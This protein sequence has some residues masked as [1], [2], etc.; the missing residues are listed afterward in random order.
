VG[1]TLEQICQRHATELFGEWLPKNGAFPLLVKLLDCR[2]LLS[3]QVHPNDELARHLTSEVFGKT[4]AW[5]I[6][7]AEPDA[8]IYA[9]FQSGVGRD[10]VE[11][12][13]SAG[14][15]EEVLHT[16]TPRRGD[17]VFLPAGTVHA[18][19]GGVVMAEVQ[20]A[21]DVTFRLYDWNRVGVD[22]KPRQLHIQE[23]LQSIDWDAGPV[24]PV[25]PRPIAGMPTGVQTERLVASPYF[26]MDRVRLEASELAEPGGQLIIWMVLE[27]A[28][29]LR[30]ECGYGASF[31]RG[32]TV[33][34]PASSQAPSWQ[35][36]TAC[37]KVTL[38]RISL[39]RGP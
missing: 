20:Q 3:I 28:G 38:L 16:I 23:A 29:E 8:R 26:E 19:G 35:P 17:C 4:E 5:L 13:L 15:L 25:V 1:R 9:G 30:T 18:V 31:R 12:R 32:D 37:E 14:T 10:E 27:G 39:P 34:V 2:E 36:A 21:S 24:A 7:E 11:R 6:L 22:G 33:L